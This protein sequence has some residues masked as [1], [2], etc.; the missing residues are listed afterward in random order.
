MINYPP[1]NNQSPG[2]A[3]E[4]KKWHERGKGLFISLITEVLKLIRAASSERIADGEVESEG[5]A[6]GDIE[7]VSRTDSGYLRFSGAGSR[8][9]DGGAPG[10]MQ[11][12]AEITANHH[13]AYVYTQTHSC[14]ECYIA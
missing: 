8:I 7:V 13:H 6:E 10:I 5:F 4:V 3:S 9:V 14:A 12:I 2:H 1:V 11:A